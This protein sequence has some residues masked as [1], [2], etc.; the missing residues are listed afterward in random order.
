MMRSDD[1]LQQELI[2]SI[3]INL[4]QCML[5]PHTKKSIN[6]IALL[7]EKGEL[8]IDVCLADEERTKVRLVAKPVDAETA[9][10]RRMKAKK[11]D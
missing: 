8:D 10:I 2:L 11:D 1:L 4:I 7:T 5:D 3:V 9:N 6:L